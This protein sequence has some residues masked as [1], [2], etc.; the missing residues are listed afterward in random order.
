MRA[1]RPGDGDCERGEAAGLANI[2]ARRGRKGEGRKATAGGE[3]RGGGGEEGGEREG[4]GGVEGATEAFTR[5]V[6]G[7]QCEFGG[8]S[9]RHCVVKV[10][11][12]FFLFHTIFLIRA[13]VFS[14]L[15]LTATPPPPLPRSQ[16]RQSRSERFS[17]FVFLSC[18]P[19]LPSSSSPFRPFPPLSNPVTD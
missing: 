13:D 8:D 18:F 9:A 15:P 3:G 19:S 2:P 10:C 7:G 5:G 14:Y 4:S 17:R 16:T 6:G 11:F 12:S 1:S